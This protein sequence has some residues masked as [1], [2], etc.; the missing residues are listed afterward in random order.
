MCVFMQTFCCMLRLRASGLATETDFRYYCAVKK[1]DCIHALKALGEES[2]VR[3]LRML[4]TRERS[5]NEI[6]ESLG[7]T[8]YNVSK[9]LRVLR[10]ASLLEQEKHGQQRVYS[11]A[12]DFREHL[13]EN[14]NVLD[15][16][17]CTF[18]FSKLPK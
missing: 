18:D 9:H 12:A 10:E 6:A 17:C 2:R 7:M 5:V 3:I 1:F 13:A 11:L 16:G 14:K 4:M 8:Q 15:L